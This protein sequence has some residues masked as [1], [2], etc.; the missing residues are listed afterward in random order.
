[1]NYSPAEYVLHS[2]FAAQKVLYP[3]PHFYAENVFEESV[4]EDLL[5]KLP[6]EVEASDFPSRAIGAITIPWMTTQ[7]F[8][9][10]LFGFFRSEYK[11][12]FQA[13]SDKRFKLETR[14]VKDTQGYSIG[15]HTDASPKV[16]SLL[17]YLP[18]DNSREYMGTSIFVPKDRSFGCDGGPHYEFEDFEKVWT[19]PMRRNS[20]FGFWKTRNS[21]HGV[22][23][24]G[25]PVERW[26]LLFNV[27][28]EAALQRQSVDNTPIQDAERAA[29]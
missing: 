19:A 20:M 4:Y 8:C 26:T 15:P 17:F 11:G 5:A 23:P 21:F 9:A 10:G 29:A 22:E 27:Y 3:F 16:I 28:D 2:I 12:R 25:V 7:S 1:M 18:K 24:I 6:A 14:L 13:A